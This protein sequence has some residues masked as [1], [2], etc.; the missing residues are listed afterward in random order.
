M[1]NWEKLQQKLTT[2]AAVG[3]GNKKRK[4]DSK[5]ENKQHSSSADAALRKGFS[6]VGGDK[7][8]DVGKHP[9]L[10]TAKDNETIM[11]ILDAKAAKIPEH[12]RAK[13][14]GLDCEMVGIGPS[15]K[16]SVLA[17]CCMT[18]FTGEVLYDEFV[19]PSDFVTDFRTEYSGVRKRDLRTGVAISLLQVSCFVYL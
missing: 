19:R 7:S 1:S 10:K 4:F 9:D 2:V 17:R 8:K 16:C 11:S 13:Y 5:K 18:S 6:N 15:G 14:V 3:S 12:V